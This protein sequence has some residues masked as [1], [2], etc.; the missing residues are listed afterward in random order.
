MSPDDLEHSIFQ[1]GLM[2][3]F[4]MSGGDDKATAA[5]Q[6]FTKAIAGTRSKPV[7]KAVDALQKQ[8][9]GSEDELKDYL[10]QVIRKG[11]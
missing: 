3:S 1:A 8:L 9:E 11:S 2:I 5:L 6:D 4:G 10:Q 7:T